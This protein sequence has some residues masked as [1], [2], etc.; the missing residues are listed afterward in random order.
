MS[1]HAEAIVAPC[2]ISVIGQVCN[3][4]AEY[5]ISL[6]PFPRMRSLHLDYGEMNATE[7]IADQKVCSALTVQCEEIFDTGRHLPEFVFRRPFARYFAVEYAH[8][9]SL[10]FGVLLSE[11]SSIFADESV[12]YRMLDPQPWDGTL[13]GLISFTPAILT[14]R[15]VEVMN[16]TKGST[17]ILA[18]A[19]L[20]VFWGSSL[21][22]GIFADRISWELAVIATQKDVNVSK[23][24]GWPCFN[25]E[26]VRSY[27]TSQYHA[28]DP[29][30]SI[31]KEFS[32]KFLSNYSL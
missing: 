18:G 15:Y 8:I 22:W 5:W 7:L 27:M 1:N 11:M 13:F 14:D 16:P 20:G 32:E 30:D 31:A 17:H 3:L 6:S 21:E 19:N 29:S 4:S 12:N 25:P 2:K 9:Y 26:Q 10:K 24:L 23:I 28:K